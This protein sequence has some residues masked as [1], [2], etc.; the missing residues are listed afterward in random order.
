MKTIRTYSELI[1]YN[2][3]EDRLNYLKIYGKVGIDTFG[4]DRIFNQMFYNSYEWRK[5]RNFVITR[6]NG[7]DLGLKGYEIGKYE[8][9]FIH[10][11]NPISIEDIKNN[12]SILL[13]PEFLITTVFDTHNKIHYGISNSEKI[14]FIERT[15]NDTCPWKK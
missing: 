11:M 9:I 2:T 3:F 13:D 8:K 10:H 5:T 4:F 15:A 1:K 7:C 12:S 6:D 14:L